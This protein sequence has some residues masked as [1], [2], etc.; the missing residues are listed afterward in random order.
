MTKDLSKK[1]LEKIHE[2]E[3]KPTPKWECLVKKY[4]W[5]FVLVIAVLFASLTIAV[6][7]FL[8]KSTDWQIYLYLNKTRLGFVLDSLPYFWLGL[9]AVFIILGYFNYRHTSKGYRYRFSTIMIVALLIVGSLG[10]TMFAVGI[11]QTVENGVLSNFET[12]HK[13][14]FEQDLKRW[15]QPNNGLLA[16]EIIDVEDRQKVKLEDFTGK[17]WNIVIKGNPKLPKDFHLIIKNGSRIRIIGVKVSEDIFEAHEVKPWEKNF[18]K[19]GP[20]V[21]KKMK[22]NPPEERIR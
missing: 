22:E 8:I 21:L 6:S 18:V 11:G 10:G 9:F 2:Q 15:T 14:G 19:P 12:Y 16:G 7:L 17:Q 13:L 5:W 3:L 20:V 4:A 1:V